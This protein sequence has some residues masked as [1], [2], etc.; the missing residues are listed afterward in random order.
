MDANAWRDLLARFSDEAPH[1]FALLG[2]PMPSW[3]AVKVVWKA[4]REKGVAWLYQ[5]LKLLLATP[6]DFLVPLPPGST[7]AFPT[8]AKVKSK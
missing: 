3:Q 2:S 1:I 5:T 7:N 6:R 8:S 4:R